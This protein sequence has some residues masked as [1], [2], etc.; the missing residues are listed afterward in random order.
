MKLIQSILVAFNQY[1]KVMEIDL[2]PIILFIGNYGSGKT[3]V[4]VNFALESLS[5][6]TPV[7]VADLDLVNPYFR[8]REVRELLESRGIEV[9]LP[10]KG[11][12]NADLPILVPQ[13]QGAIL[14]QKGITILDVGGDD[15]GANVLGSLKPVLEQSC[16]DMIQVVN[17]MR[18]FTETADGALQITRE[19][20]KAARTK[21]TGIVGNTHLMQHTTTDTIYEGYEYA[22]EVAEKLDVPLVF[23]TCD[24]ELLADLDTS[25]FDCPVLPFTRQL[26]PPWQRKEKLG[27][28][29]FLLS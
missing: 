19:I 7:Q 23:I 21:I 24:K 14:D 18:P 4:S 16:F 26:L 2:K 1:P 28:K 9:I 12:L 27:S 11:L 15:V 6:G 8:S 29:N 5:S 17:A 25:G 3:E 10:E 13:I 20:E 22:V